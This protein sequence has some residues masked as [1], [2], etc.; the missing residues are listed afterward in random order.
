MV[1]GKN[2][3][4]ISLIDDINSS[5]NRKSFRFDLLF[6]LAVIAAAS[7]GLLI[8]YSATR[9]LLPAESGGPLYYLKRQSIYLGA[10]V[11]LFT[12]LQFVNYR[13]IKVFWWVA[14][15]VGLLSLAA[16]LVFGYEVHGSKSWIDLG[17]A[18]L[19][20]KKSEKVN[21]ISFKKLLL[22]TAAALAFILLVLMEPDFGTAIIFLLIF[23]G[24]LFISGA[25]FFYILAI[26][27]AAAGG[28]FAGLKMGITGFLF[29]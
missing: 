29:F 5:K 3:R 18:L 26:T 28:F 12:G 10:G 15:S 17:A 25:N 7:F 21:N 22:S 14:A 24:M 2:Y 9:N 23:L 19:S 13:K 8:I 27:A 1:K 16:V 20:K 4:Y 6:F 11:L